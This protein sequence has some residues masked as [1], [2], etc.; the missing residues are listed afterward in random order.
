MSAVDFTHA[1]LAEQGN[2]FAGSELLS[3][4]EGHDARILHSL[5]FIPQDAALD[6]IHALFVIV[7]GNDE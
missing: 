2:N 5:E 3:W 6:E 4:R 7:T 1:T